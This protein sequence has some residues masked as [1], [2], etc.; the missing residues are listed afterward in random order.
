[1]PAGSSW[2]IAFVRHNPGWSG[3]FSKATEFP[4]MDF[5]VTGHELCILLQVIQINLLAQQAK[6]GWGHFFGLL[7][8][9]YLE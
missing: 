2:A 8:A 6:L 3:L 1:M 7:L 5:P 4:V 9:P